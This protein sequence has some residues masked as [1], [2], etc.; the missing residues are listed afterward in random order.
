MSPPAGYE[1]HRTSAIGANAVPTP[2]G[3]L[4]PGD[5]L[6]KYTG[7][8]SPTDRVPAPARVPSA[9]GAAPGGGPT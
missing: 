7:A 3:Y 4:G 1:T 9:P 2:R 8:G 5:E 6:R